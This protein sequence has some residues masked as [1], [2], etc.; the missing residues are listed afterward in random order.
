[1]VKMKASPERFSIIKQ[2]VAFHGQMA[3]QVPDFFYGEIQRGSH[4][5]NRGLLT[6]RGM[7][8]LIDCIQAMKEVLGDEVGLALDCGP[9]FTVPD[10]IRLA[11]AVEPLNVAGRYADRRL[12]TVGGTGFLSGGNAKY[13]NTDSHW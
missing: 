12:C 1:M 13:L 3:T 9:G 5:A 4:H 8:H 11:Q 2:G 10:A 6:E 7:K